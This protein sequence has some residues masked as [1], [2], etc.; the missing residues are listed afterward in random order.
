M[1]ILPKA[2]LLDYNTF[3]IDVSC[4]QLIIIEEESEITSLFKAKVFEEKHFIIGGGSNLLFVNDYDANIIHIR[5]KGIETV[6]EDSDFV[7]LR[8]AAGMVWNDFVDYCLSNQYYGIENLIGIPGCVGSSAV[9]NVGAYGVEAKDLIYQVE[10]YNIRTKN[11]FVLYNADCEFSYRSSIFKTKLKNQCLIVNVVFRLSKKEIYNLEYE[12]LRS[13]LDESDLSLQ[14]VS[15]MVLELRNSKLPDI[16]EI[17]SAG[18]FFKNPIVSNQHLRQLLQLYPNLIHYDT[19]D[20]NKKLAAGQL[21]DL[22]GWKGVRDG[23]AGVYPLQALVLVNYGKATGKE[24]L[25]LAKK[26]QQDILEKFN[27]NLEPEV[28]IIQ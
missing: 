4:Q 16:S 22:A 10:G 7:Y 20:G 25:D 13:R 3:K 6:E 11:D 21:I 9:Q 2:S 5:T 23:D 27:I 15:E 18:S 28:N 1:E 19:D 26:I 24:I 17:G 14:Y 12:A 8:V